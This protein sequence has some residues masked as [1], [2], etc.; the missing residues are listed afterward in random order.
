M[1]LA[2][3]EGLGHRPLHAVTVWL[4]LHPLLLHPFLDRLPSVTILQFFAPPPPHGAL[5][6][7]HTLGFASVSPPPFLHGVGDPRPPLPHPRPPHPLA[8]S[9]STAAPCVFL[10]LL[11]L[12]LLLPIRLLLLRLLLLL[13]LPICMGGRSFGL[14]F[15][16]NYLLLLHMGR[17]FRGSPMPAFRAAS[18]SVFAWG[19]NFGRPFRQKIP[20]PPFLL[21][22]RNAR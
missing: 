10:L 21:Y 14:P 2:P 18:S 6:F 1:T 12:L 9:P 8:I 4:S 17:G 19:P 7:W 20:P 22:H 3:H 11:L 16:K 13:L 15:G 5:L